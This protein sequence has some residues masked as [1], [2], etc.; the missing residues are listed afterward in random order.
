MFRFF[1]GKWKFCFIQSYPKLLMRFFCKCL[2]GVCARKKGT[3]RT[4][5]EIVKIQK[6]CGCWFQNQQLGIKCKMF[7][8]TKADRNHLYSLIIQLFWWGAV[9]PLAASVY[10][11]NLTTQSNTKKW[12]SVYQFKK[13]TYQIDSPKKEM[14]HLFVEV[15][16]V[17]NDISSCPHIELSNSWSLVLDKIEI[18][19]LLTHFA[20]RPKNTNVP[21]SNFK[22]LTLLLNLQHCFSI[23]VQK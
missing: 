10:N 3:E 20:L 14:E 6:V 15:D 9:F 4:N 19:V 1:P 8:H 12:Y 2:I 21:D 16:S 17:G 22:F 7:W 23:K 11:R 18:V 13:F 5:K